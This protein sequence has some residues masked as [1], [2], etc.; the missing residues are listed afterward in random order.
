MLDLVRE[1]RDEGDLLQ[2]SNRGWAVAGTGK[3]PAASLDVCFME[4][5]SMGVVLVKYAWRSDDWQTR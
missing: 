4:E 3:A 1:G 5:R 2:G